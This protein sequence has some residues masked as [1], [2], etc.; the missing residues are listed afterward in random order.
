MDKF[1]ISAI[2]WAK[3]PLHAWTWNFSVFQYYHWILCPYLVLKHELNKLLLLRIWKRVPVNANNWLRNNNFIKSRYLFCI[4]CWWCRREVWLDRG[5][6]TLDPASNTMAPV[7]F[8]EKYASMTILS[9][10]MALVVIV[11]IVVIVMTSK[12]PPVMTKLACW[13]LF[14][15][16]VLTC[17]VISV[18][19]HC[20]PV[21]PRGFL[22]LV[23]HRFR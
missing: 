20:G 11:V 15:L 5:I 16:W 23:K 7:C 22:H 9:A 17:L 3:Y 19:T 18:S 12:I 8:T 4:P 6:T 13:Q 10:L 2:M 1:V 21:T 14:I